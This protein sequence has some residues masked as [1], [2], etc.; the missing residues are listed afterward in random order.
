MK[1]KKS[2][3]LKDF[4]LIDGYN[5]LALLLKKDKRLKKLSFELQRDELVEKT[6][7]RF[8]NTV[9]E[10]R[11]VF[12]GKSKDEFRAFKELVVVFHPDADAYIERFCFSNAQNRI[13]LVT[14]DNG[15]I[16]SVQGKFSSLIRPELFLS[17]LNK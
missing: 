6:Y 2:E 5:V 13:K 12:D 15:I 3:A 17:M 4:L 14:S 8:V 16:N 1:S 9:D 7:N 11:I 10:I